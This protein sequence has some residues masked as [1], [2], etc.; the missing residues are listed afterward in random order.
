MAAAGKPAAAEN[1]RGTANGWRVTVPI[2]NQVS[3]DRERQVSPQPGRLAVANINNRL[4]TGDDPFETFA[5]MIYHFTITT[6]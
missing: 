6:Q 5:E 2:S 3:S 4:T 1:I